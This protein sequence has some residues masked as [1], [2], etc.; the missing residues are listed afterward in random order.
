MPATQ[1]YCVIFH[2]TIRRTK[3][4]VFPNRM[5]SV[6]LVTIN[7][8]HTVTCQYHISLSSLV[9]HILEAVTRFGDL[10]DFYELLIDMDLC[11]DGEFVW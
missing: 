2:C 11:G 1:S 5:Q 7:L 9:C 8:K 10:G 4:A 6:V 3:I